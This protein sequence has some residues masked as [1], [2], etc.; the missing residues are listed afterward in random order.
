MG[1]TRTEFQMSMQ[2][3]IP[4]EPGWLVTSR[5]ITTAAAFVALL[6]ALHQPVRW[7]IGLADEIAGLQARVTALETGQ[8]HTRP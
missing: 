6:Y 5:T 4:G 8:G 3:S 1:E 2:S 7:L